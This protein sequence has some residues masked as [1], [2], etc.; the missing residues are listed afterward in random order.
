MTQ[1]LSHFGEHALAFT[2]LC[3]HGTSNYNLAKNKSRD[4]VWTLQRVAF[5]AG[6]FFAMQAVQPLVPVYAMVLLCNAAYY[7][8]PEA[9]LGMGAYLFYRGGLQLMAAAGTASP[10]IV[11]M[12]GSINLISGI[13]AWKWYD[14]H[15]LND[16]FFNDLFIRNAE[17]IAPI[18]AERFTG[19]AAP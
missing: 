19:K 15:F 16:N 8:F 13:V 2:R 5:A 7:A 4:F 1:S 17:Y 11:I 6:V 12:I 10:E 18:A 3:L 9:S 14:K